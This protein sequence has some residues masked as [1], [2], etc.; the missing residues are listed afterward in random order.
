MRRFLRG[1]LAV[2]FAFSCL[3]QIGNACP[4]AQQNLVNVD[5]EITEY[6]AWDVNQDGIRDYRDL[7][8]ID[9]LWLAYLDN[10]EDTRGDINRDGVVDID[11]FHIVLYHHSAYPRTPSALGEIGGVH[12]NSGMF[13]TLAGDALQARLQKIRAESNRFPK[14]RQAIA[15][16]EH[17]LV[18]GQPHKTQLLANYPNPFNP[19]TWIPYHLAKTA[20]VRITIYNGHGAVVR[21]LVLG[22]QSAGYYTS[23]GRA[24]YW[25]GCNDVGERVGSGIYFYQL[26]A[27]YVSPIRKMVILK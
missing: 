12:L 18:V 9:D 27:N 24:A 14:Y 2:C 19:E 23:Q 13:D 26:H 16:L 11:D 25:D 21:H 10:P 22:Y 15:F 8:L 4:V 5:L 17:L 6:P 1:F 20:D 3:L 7:D